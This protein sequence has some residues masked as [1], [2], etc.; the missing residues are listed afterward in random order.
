ML[1]IITCIIIMIIIIIIVV[2]VVNCYHYHSIFKSMY[3]FVSSLPN[4]YLTMPCHPKILNSHNKYG[5]IKN[6]S[7]EIVSFSQDF[8][9]VKATYNLNITTPNATSRYS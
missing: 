3:F 5:P 1:L 6:K 7:Q 2:V 4:S 9:C 8:N